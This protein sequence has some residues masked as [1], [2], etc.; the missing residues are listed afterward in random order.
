MLAVVDYV[1]GKGPPPP[2]LKL[3][4]RCE[5]YRAL[6]E[7]GGVLEQEAGLLE[8]MELAE[9]VCAT[10]QMW[11]TRQAGHEGEWAEA[12]PEEWQMVMAILELQNGRD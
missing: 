6:P 8:R 5:R 2:M 11:R 9:R 12:H 7:S 10:W 3:A 1:E 4:R